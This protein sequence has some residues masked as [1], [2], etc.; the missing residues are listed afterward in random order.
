MFVQFADA[1]GAVIIATF[2]EPQNAAA[3]PNQ[4]I[5]EAT[6]ARWATYYA[7][8]PAFAQAGLTPPTTPAAPTPAQAYAAFIAG[9]L[10]VTSTGTPA[11]SGTYAIDAGSQSD[12]AVEAQFISTFAAFTTGATTDL[13]W[14]MPNGVTVVFPTT[15]TFLSFAKAA[16]MAVAAARLALAQSAAMPSAS[17]TIP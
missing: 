13:P 15:A 6:D 4:G 17:V 5:V 9:G 10:T 3:F 16:G 8:L 14:P 2:A 12:I 11:I 7:T 1:T